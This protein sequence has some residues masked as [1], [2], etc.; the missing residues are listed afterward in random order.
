[1]IQDGSEFKPHD[2]EELMNPKPKKS[3]GI[4]TVE[5]AIKFLL[6]SGY[7]V[8]P[9]EPPPRNPVHSPPTAA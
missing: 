6:D 7:S 8:V 2:Y 9:T 5:E 3:K 4:T 1:M